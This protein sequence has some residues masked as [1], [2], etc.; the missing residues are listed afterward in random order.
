MRRLETFAL[1]DGRA[2]HLSTASPRLSICSSSEADN[3]MAS[4]SIGDKLTWPEGCSQYFGLSPREREILEIGILT[5]ER[6]DPG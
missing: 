4:K 2:Q 3:L 6:C 5:A 1:L